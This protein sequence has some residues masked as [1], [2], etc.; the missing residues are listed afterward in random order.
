MKNCLILGSGR[1]GSS[2]LAGMLRNSGYYLGDDYIQRRPANPKGYY[3]DREINCINDDLISY[4]EGRRLRSRIRRRLPQV[5][6][7]L[8]GKEL[9]RMA[10]WLAKVPPH[11]TLEV[12]DALR[13]RIEERVSHVPFCYKDPRFSYTIDTWRPSLPDDVRLLVVFRDPITTARSI[14][15]DIHETGLVRRVK[16]TEEHAGAIWYSMYQNILARMKNPDEYL[17]LHYQQIVDGDANVAI[18]EFLQAPVDGEFADRRVSRSKVSGLGSMPKVWSR[19]YEK[20]LELSQTSSSKL[21][22]QSG[23]GVV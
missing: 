13:L 4:N 23:S 9:P 22:Q 11:M 17:F 2:M 8:L 10:H 15:R 7:S 12:T 18:E 19:T 5:A 20:L 1:S 6:R 16:L 21:Q 14:V 3:E